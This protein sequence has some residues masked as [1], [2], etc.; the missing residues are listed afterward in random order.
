MSATILEVDPSRWKTV[1]LKHQIVGVKFLI[2]RLYGGLFDEMGSGKTKQTIDAACIF[3]EAGLVDTVVVV[4]PST[5]RTSWKNPEWGE[6]KLH[7]WVPYHV[8]E[9]SSRNT[10]LPDKRYTAGKL[11]FII[12]NYELLRMTGRL[13][14]FVPQIKNRKIMLVCDESSYIKTWN[15]KQ[16]RSIQKL[17]NYCERVYL[18]NG[19]PIG[20]S[21]LDLYS[22]M[23][24]LH[25]SILR[26]NNYFTFRNRYAIITKVKDLPRI[27]GYQHLDEL[28]AKI[29][30]HVLRREKSECIDLP[31]KTYRVEEIPLT[32]ETWRVYKDMRDQMI[33]WLDTHTTASA[34]VAIVKILRLAQVTSGFIGGIETSTDNFE[35]GMTIAPDPFGPRPEFMKLPQPQK[36]PLGEAKTPIREV[37]HEKQTWFENWLENRIEENYNFRAIGWSRFRAEQSRAAQELSK[38]YKVHRIYGGQPEKEREHAISEFTVATS[39]GPMV[40]LGNPAAG[41]LGLNLVTSCHAVYLSNDFSRIK[42]AQSEDRIHRKGQLHAV[43]IT[44][45]LATGPQGQRTIDHQIHRALRNYE[46]VANYTMAK[47][48]QVLLEE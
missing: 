43:T 31:P 19:T 29:A 45:V 46:D 47:W 11:T 40:L 13:K 32:P 23:E 33:V 3:F 16:T 30:P 44:D 20:N 22:Q 6:I 35:E 48:R 24:T 39:G 21:P 25:Q 18:L 17:R 38:R 15:S 36:L 27:T 28:S 9:F 37:G 12:T 14:E 42:R 5:V 4:C 7:C 1:P 34:S 41:G 10:I 26:V 2:E 8:A